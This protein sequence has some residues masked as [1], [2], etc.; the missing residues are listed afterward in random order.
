MDCGPWR[1]LAVKYNKGLTPLLT[2]VMQGQLDMVK[3]LISMGSSV[4]EDKDS[5][6]ST[7]FILACFLGNLESRIDR[8]FILL[9]STE[10]LS[11]SSWG[12]AG[13]ATKRL[14]PYCSHQGVTGHS[15]P[16]L[17]EWR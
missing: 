7:P 9:F 5:D 8:G 12:F 2:A 15:V 4:E 13:S 3:W 1:I 11:S 14:Y 16:V 6:G 10:A 17:V